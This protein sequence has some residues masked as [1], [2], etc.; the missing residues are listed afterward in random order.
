MKF[1]KIWSLL[2][3]WVSGCSLPYFQN[4]NIV[5]RLGT[6]NSLGNIFWWF[7]K[8]KKIPIEY[9][10][11]A[12]VAW[13]P[14]QFWLIFL[15]ILSLPWPPHHPHLSTLTWESWLRKPLWSFQGQKF[16]VPNP[17][18]AHTERSLNRD[19]AWIQGHPQA[20]SGWDIRSE[21]KNPSPWL[22]FPFFF[23]ISNTQAKSVPDSP[24]PLG[25]TL[26]TPSP[27]L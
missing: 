7:Q 27:K 13:C 8:E 5:S 6:K 25:D 24:F 12:K 16:Y 11:Q 23:F 17:V 18:P 19:A 21:A 20:K 4:L 14:F 22:T 3:L 9:F 15:T 10:E 2:F 26:S 1:H